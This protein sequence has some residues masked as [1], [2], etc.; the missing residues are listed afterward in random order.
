MS[1]AQGYNVK[2]A[3]N[4]IERVFNGWADLR[5][6]IETEWPSIVNTLQEEW[7]GEDEQDYETKLSERINTLSSNS[8]SLVSTTRDTIIGLTESWHE[9][10]LKNTL[11][12]SVATSRGVGVAEFDYGTSDVDLSVVKPKE[13]TFGANDDRGL[14]QESSAATIKTTVETYVDAIKTKAS[15]LYNEITADKAFFGEQTASINKYI[16]AVGDAIAEVN[17]AIKDLYE[18]LDRLAGT[19]YTESSSQVSQTFVE[20]QATVE[21]SLSGLNGRWS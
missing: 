17:V 9:F 20:N 6:T 15:A 5:R 11:D 19:Q 1:I 10:Q 14:R 13:K 12:G 18:A 21:D 2:E 7:I 16:V 4:I 8:F 3:E